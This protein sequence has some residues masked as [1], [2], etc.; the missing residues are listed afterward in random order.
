M[1]EKAAK[2]PRKVSEKTKETA[3][4]CGLAGNKSRVMTTATF[5]TDKTVCGFTRSV[6]NW[7]PGSPVSGEPPPRSAE[8]PC[9]VSDW[10]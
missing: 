7:G 1:R 6:G 8:A 9:P 4:Q 3:P 10:R 2:T 5:P